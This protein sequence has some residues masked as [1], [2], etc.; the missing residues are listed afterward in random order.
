M[1]AA[2]R[3]D[4]LGDAARSCGAC[5]GDALVAARHAYGRG[6]PWWWAKG[7]RRVDVTM[8]TWIRRI[9]FVENDKGS[10]AGTGD[11][12]A[13]TLDDGPEGGI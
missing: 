10:G 13:G 7:P 11:A 4:H 3:R 5:V 8:V 2:R 6:A 12:H 1:T 9:T